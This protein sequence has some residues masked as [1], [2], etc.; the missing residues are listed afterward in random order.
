MRG[1]SPDVAVGHDDD[2]MA[3]A[4]RHVDE[5]RDLS[6]EPMRF[7]FDHQLEIA[8]GERASKPLDRC[9]GVVVGTLDPKDDLNI[10]PIV[11]NAERAEVIEQT[12]LVAVKRP[13][14]GYPRRNGGGP[15]G[16]LTRTAAPGGGGH[17][18]KSRAADGE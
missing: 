7:G 12:R 13:E 9:D 4:R 11:L 17:Q 14:E 5:A 6:I 1:I 2:V 16:A 8:A 3:D 10:A 18:Q 15:G